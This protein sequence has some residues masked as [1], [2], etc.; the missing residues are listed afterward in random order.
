MATKN[1]PGKFDCYTNAEPDEP[2]FILLGRDPTAKAVLRYWERL[3]LLHELNKPDDEQIVEAH[4]CADSMERYLRQKKQLDSL[5]ASRVT[6]PELAISGQH[7]A[8]VRNGAFAGVD[9]TNLSLL[10]RME[11]LEEMAVLEWFHILNSDESHRTFW[12]F[13]H[14]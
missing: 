9:V 6:P 4:E 14:D 10:E 5:N 7:C 3:R 1:N 8:V 2:M 12:V 11:V 13:Y